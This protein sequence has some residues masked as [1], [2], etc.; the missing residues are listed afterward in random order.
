[1]TYDVTDM[2]SF[3]NAKMWLSEIER[4]ACGNVVKLLVGNKADM[5]SKRAVKAEDA[6]RF[7]DQ[8][9]MLFMEASAKNGTGVE[10]AFLALVKQIFDARI[11]AGPAPTVKTQEKIDLSR[12]SEISQ[13]KGGCCG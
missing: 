10:E 12:G 13:S 4:Y 7:A 1:M 2:V 3:T 5:E 9:N 8:Y 6:K 11:A